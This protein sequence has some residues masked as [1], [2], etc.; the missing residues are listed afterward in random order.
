MS[1]CEVANLFLFSLIVLMA[2]VWS[3]EKVRIKK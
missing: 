2:I 1:E 3:V